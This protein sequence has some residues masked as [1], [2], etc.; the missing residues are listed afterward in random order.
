MTVRQSILAMIALVLAGWLGTGAARA[1]TVDLISNGGFET[2]NLSGWS[3]TSNGRGEHFDTVR[4]SNGFFGQRAMNGRYDV[5][6]DP[7]YA[8]VSTLTQ[9]FTVP[10]AVVNATL[11]FTQKIDLYGYFNV[12]RQQFKAS[13]VNSVGAVISQVY[14]TAQSGLQ[15]GDGQASTLSFDLTSL[16]QANAGSVLGV[17]FSLEAQTY[18]MS[19]TLDDIAMMVETPAVVPL[20]PT[21]WMMLAALGLFVLIGWRKRQTRDDTACCAQAA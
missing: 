7:R 5:Q 11:N 9:F 16:M 18:S 6:Y 10:D 14:S 19:A 13:I 17:Q 12:P 2:G 8:G 20:P 15:L 1:V 3:T 4:G 21:I